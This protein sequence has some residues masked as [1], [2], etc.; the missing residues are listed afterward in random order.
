MLTVA[1]VRVGNKYGEDYV[2]KLLAMVTRHL[3]L[4]HRFVVVRDPPKLSGAEGC[5]SKLWLFG[6]AFNDGPVLYFDLDT[7]ISGPID[8]LVSTG[9]FRAMLDPRPGPEGKPKLNS[10]VM[11]WVPGARS[12][13]IHEAHMRINPRGKPHGEWRGDQEFIES[14]LFGAWEPLPGVHSFKGGIQI[15]TTVAV[16]HGKP[17]PHEVL[18]VPYVA[19]HWR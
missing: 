9:G 4:P 17:K 7:V 12:R 13:A 18:D 10:S 5:W 14:M 11:S 2:R 8:N 19:A 16:F 15:D 6:P 3:S 1:C